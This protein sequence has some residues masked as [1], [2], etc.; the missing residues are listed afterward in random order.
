MQLH[1]CMMQGLQMQDALERRL[2]CGEAKTAGPITVRRERGSRRGGE[3]DRESEAGNYSATGTS[4]EEVRK[5]ILDFTDSQ[6][7]VTPA[8]GPGIGSF[9]KSKRFEALSGLA[10]RL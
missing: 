7:G 2:Q 10:E 1:D 3:A 6:A 4:F 5:G 8:N 9:W